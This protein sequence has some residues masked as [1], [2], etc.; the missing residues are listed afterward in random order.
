MTDIQKF[1][2]LFD[3]PQVVQQ[4]CNLMWGRFLARVCEAFV[5]EGF[6][7]EF[8]AIADSDG[9]IDGSKIYS[10]LLCLTDAGRDFCGLPRAS[11]AV[12]KPAAKTKHRTL[13]D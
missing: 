11:I 1:L 10:R 3:D 6:R 8:L 13:F 2:R 9:P 12:E 4:A 5:S 7:R